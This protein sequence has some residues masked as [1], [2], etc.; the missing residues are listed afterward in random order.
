M[1]EI[2]ADPLRAA[3]AR[4]YPEREALAVSV[5]ERLSSGWESDVYALD[6]A[7]GAASRRERQALVLRLYPGTPSGALG[8]AAKAAHEYRILAGLA[9]AGFPVPRVDLLETDPA[10]LGMP[11]VVMERATG[12]VLAEYLRRAP[13]GEAQAW[14]ERSMALLVALHRLDPAPF[15]EPGDPPPGPEDDHACLRR[16][17][18]RWMGC[19]RA[20][21]FGQGDGAPEELAA[22]LDR[23]LRD[24]PPAPPALVHLDW[25]AGNILLRADGSPVVIDWTSAEVSDPRVDLGWSVVLAQGAG[26]QQ[27]EALI[28]AYERAAG[29]PVA[30]L[31]FFVTLARWRR[32]WSM[33]A[34]LACG[35]GAVGMRPGAEETI[36]GALP[37]LAEHYRALREATGLRLPAVEAVLPPGAARGT[38]GAGS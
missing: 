6:A 26:P 3:L 27:Q 11:F 9:R 34:A 15:V 21:P 13:P 2:R 22:W 12:P 7:W 16:A 4:R 31:G 23:A 18:A 29:A 35:A 25:H 5:G 24:V 38:R 14:L 10:P 36:R 20:V 32:V 33:A 37:L 19:A 8:A 17:L 28:R 30:G 1:P